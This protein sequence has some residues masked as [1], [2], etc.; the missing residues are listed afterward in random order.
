MVGYATQD[1]PPPALIRIIGQSPHISDVSY[2]RAPPMSPSLY[3]RG[4]HGIGDN[5][6]QRAVIRIL[7]Q[8]YN[9]TLETSWA[10][11]YHDFLAEGGLRV[12]GRPVN[13]RTQWKNF[14]RPAEQALFSPMPPHHHVTHAIR[15]SY[16]THTIEQTGSKTITEALFRVAGIGDRFH[17]ADFRLP[18][19]PEWIATADR[20][21][22]SWPT[23]GKPIMI[24]RPLCIRPE[25]MGSQVRNANVDDYRAIT[26]QLH[27]KYFIV[28]IADLEP[29]KEWLAASAAPVDMDF[30]NGEFPFEILAAIFHRADLI[31]TSG[32]FAAMLGPAVETP[33][34][35]ILGG[36]EPP[37]WCADGGKFSPYLA[38]APNPPCKCG[39]SGCA[40][41]CAKKLNLD[42]ALGAVKGFTSMTE[43]IHVQP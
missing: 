8:A 19:K 41:H 31:F 40:K 7:R 18:L 6:H 25:W 27:E 20:I 17:E 12:V 9:V 15:F 11:L 21:I 28:S 35:S 23:G 36:Y 43:S 37:E 14:S 22:G 2:Q 42:Y 16:A 24:Y 3:I 29:T 38:L 30:H 32:G 33:T 39:S 26:E 5:L 10:S 1:L 4:M 34:I 13:L